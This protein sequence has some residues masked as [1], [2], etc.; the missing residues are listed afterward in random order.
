M[1]RVT[2]ATTPGGFPVGLMMVVERLAADDRAGAAQGFAEDALYAS[3]EPA[4]DETSPRRIADGRDAI[5]LTLPGN[6]VRLEPQICLHDGSSCFVEGRL[7]GLAADATF[8]WSAQLDGDGLLTRVLAQRC[9]PV[10]PSPTWR[11]AQPES[12]ADAHAVLDRYFTNLQ[13]G[14]FP[15]A[16]ACFSPNVLY[17]HP[18]YVAGGTRVTFRGRDQLLDGFTR[19]RPRSTIRQVVITCLQAGL[20]GFVEGI[21]EGIPNGGSFVSSFALDQNGLI[22]RYVAFYTVSRVARR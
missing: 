21:A 16:V 12:S 9:P 19:V 17:D 15:E 18:P 22:E 2:R 1:A 4:G 20:D 11:L 10:E 7:L 14:R 13:A 8:S 5:A 3:W 6:G